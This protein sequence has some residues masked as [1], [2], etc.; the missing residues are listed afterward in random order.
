MGVM[1]D[2]GAVGMVDVR[3]CSQALR[4]EG[5]WIRERVDK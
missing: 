4:A 3:V 1:A 2:R 5:R